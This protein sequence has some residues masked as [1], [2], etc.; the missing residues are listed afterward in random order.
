MTGLSWAL[1]FSLMEHRTSWKTEVTEI[2]EPLGVWIAIDAAAGRSQ[3]NSLIQPTPGPRY[4]EQYAN[5]APFSV[6]I[7]TKWSQEYEGL[8]SSIFANELEKSTRAEKQKF[9]W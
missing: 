7:S 2:A 9:Y 8:T 3:P 6:F 5:Q 1:C 4:S